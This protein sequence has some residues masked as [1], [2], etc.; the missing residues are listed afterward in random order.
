MRDPVRIERMLDKLK[1]LWKANPDWRL[2]QLIFNI[3]RN[4][5]TLE[6]FDIFYVEDTIL[7][8]TLNRELDK[9]KLWRKNK[10]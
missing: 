9:L 1:E 6:T 2:C 7:E 8:I 5:N 10:L 4:T 3:A